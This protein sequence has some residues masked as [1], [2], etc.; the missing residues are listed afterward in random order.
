MLISRKF[1]FIYNQMRVI[2]KLSE[3]NLILKSK[4][5]AWKLSEDNLI[6]KSKLSAKLTPKVIHCDH[7]N[8]EQVN[9]S[10]SVIHVN[11]QFINLR[12]TNN[13]SPTEISS[14]EDLSL[15]NNM[16]VPDPGENQHVKIDLRACLHEGRVT[17]VEGLP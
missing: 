3:D 11:N 4:L 8:N 10:T 5:S 2:W 13:P 7:M 1:A 16:Q 15:L 17:L 9:E 12:N 14:N 6:L